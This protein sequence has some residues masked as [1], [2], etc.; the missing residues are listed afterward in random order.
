MN[1]NLEVIQDRAFDAVCAKRAGL[2]PLHNMI[3]ARL[4]ATHPEL[5]EY[6]DQLLA[7]YNGVG[8][9]LTEPREQYIKAHEKTLR[10]RFQ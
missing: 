10:L 1:K 6:I 9:F 8:E 4:F 5:S 3:V 7:L 2:I